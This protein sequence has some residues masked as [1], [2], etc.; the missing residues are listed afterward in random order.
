MNR[1]PVYT[2]VGV[3]V[4]LAPVWGGCNSDQT[5]TFRAPVMGWADTTFVMAVGS[6]S[7]RVAVM[8]D[9]VAVVAPTHLWKRTSFSLY[10]PDILAMSGPDTSDYD[11]DSVE[12]AKDNCP[13][14][15][16]PLQ[17]DSDGDGIGDA[18]DPYPTGDST[19]S[20]VTVHALQL[21]Q[22]PD[23]TQRSGLRLVFVKENQ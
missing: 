3:M 4:C 16:N 2:L 9:T 8:N 21:L 14:T 11:S 17:E 5:V 12:A 1:L 19:A 15:W 20:T 7:V 22:S 23:T 18:C 10:W 13:H 6:D